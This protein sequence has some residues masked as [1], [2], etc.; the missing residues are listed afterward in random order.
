[1]PCWHLTLEAVVPTADVPQRCGRGDKAMCVRDFDS[2]VR[3]SEVDQTLW[4]HID[5]VTSRFREVPTRACET[6]GM[7]CGRSLAR[8]GT[9]TKFAGKK[10]R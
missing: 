4:V 7:R 5:G 9:L 3:W 6:P 10:L 2:S 1:M 8:M